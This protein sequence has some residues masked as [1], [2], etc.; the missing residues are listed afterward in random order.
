M[1]SA[2]ETTAATRPL[3]QL[4][5]PG[6]YRPE[7]FDFDGDEAGRAYW[8][9]VYRE[10]LDRTLLAAIRESDP[11]AGGDRLADFEA[12]Y[13]AEFAALGR[14]GRVPPPGL[15]DF[16]AARS[17]LLGDHGFADPYREL[18]SREN[19]LAI[20]RRPALRDHRLPLDPRSRREHLARAVLAGNLFDVGAPQAYARHQANGGDFIEAC[21]RLPA[22]PWRF[23]QLD[24]WIARLDATPW[25]HAAVFVDNAGADIALG[26]LP[27]VEE[28]LEIGCR[29]TLAANSGPALNDV[30]AAEL[31]A[32]IEVAGLAAWTGQGALKVVATGFASPYLD[33]RRLAESAVT[34]IADADLLWLHGMG[35]A[36]ET[37]FRSAFT[38]DVLRTGVFKDALVAARC[39]AA[40][41]DGLFRFECVGGR[42]SL[43]PLPVRVP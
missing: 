10:E 18:K 35:R 31:A 26:V 17:R 3:P 25:R 19:T 2:L 37:N 21:R 4:V 13:R 8:A 1:R 42:F 28:L 27:L 14:P 22:R 32:I 39:G 20:A 9:N 16:D 41:F 7:T 5:D 11:D 23:D 29:V 38:C 34:A 30:T 24:A 43:A 12:A 15:F 36:I 6:G 33:L 40:P